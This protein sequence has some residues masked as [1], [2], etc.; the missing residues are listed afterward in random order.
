METKLFLDSVLCAEGVY[1]LFA[2]HS[3]LKKR[4]QR[5]FEDKQELIDYARE[6]DSK[7]WDTFFALSS[8][9]SSKSRKQDNVAKIRSFFLDL[10]CGPS[11]D[12]E[13]QEQALIALR[14]FCK[15]TGVP[16]PTMINSGRGVHV[17]WPLTEEKEPED[18]MSVARSFKNKLSKYKIYADPAVTSDTARVLRVPTTHNHKADPPIPVKPIGSLALEPL[19]FDMFVEIFGRDTSTTNRPLMKNAV[20][21]KL[22]GNRESSFE[23]IRVKTKAG[24]GCEQLKLI[25]TDQE[26]TSEPMWRAGLSIA[27]FC[28]DGEKAAHRLSE[29]H[30]EY[31]VDETNRKYDLIKGPYTCV[32]FDE[33]S[34]DICPNCPNWG[35]VKSPIV[36]GNRY[37]EAE[38]SSEDEN[39][40]PSYPQPYFRGANGGVYH[41]STSLDGE[42][43][44]KL[45]YHND[46][47]V[48]KRVRDP[49]AGESAVM[50]LHLPKDG[51]REFTIP[52]SAITSREEF[53]KHIASQGVA[54]TKMDELMTYTTTWINELQANSVAEKAHRQFGWTDGSMTTF[55]LGN[56]KITADAIEFNPPSDQTVGLFPAFEPKGTLEEWKE[57]M[58]FWDRDGFELYQYV[59][60]TGFGSALMEMLNASCAGMHLHS[61]ESGVAKTTAVIAGLGIYGN[62]NEL[63]LNKDDTFAS[64]MNR[65]QV[66]HSILW[67][68]DEITNLTPLQASNLIYQFAAG[69][70]RNRLT[71]SGN[72]ERYR[73]EPWSLL[74]NTTGNASI[75]ERVSMAKAMSKAEAQRMLECYV[76]N[77]RHLFDN[78]KDPYAFENGV[79]YQQYGTAAIPYVQYIMRNRDEI[80]VLLEKVKENVDRI[81]QLDTTNRFW[82]AHITA[83][84]TGLMVAKRAELINFDTKKVFKW[85]IETLLPQNKRNTETSD[86]SVFDIM[87]DFFTEHISN[88]LQIESTHDNRK[89]HDNGLDSLVIPDAI[90]RG[91]LVARYE[92]D[93]Q[94]FYVVPKILKSWCGD[95]QINYAHLLK[96]IK[97]H[98]EGKRAKV[99]LGKGTK[100]NLPPADVIVMKFSTDE[101]EESGD[102]KNL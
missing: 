26:N 40:L 91:K 41:R 62:P 36:L 63:L 90:A 81:G 6:L 44:E 71:S 11:K 32:T 29:R 58:S 43:D 30:P 66:Y 21:D 79:K 69:Q 38:T 1:C 92:T 39:E 54:V 18:W 53:R 99:R 76:P 93:T 49:E 56:K 94:K 17:Y 100:L 20:M 72:I 48:V 70:Q 59:V 45:I 87:N 57:L 25:M 61:V 8:F 37:K 13:T 82:S 77:V 51:I 35:K 4:N 101:D 68:V 31:D 86:A 64:K 88:I 22:M 5:F 102:S 10:D 97:E 42:V 46:L 47:Y 14:N 89:M 73:G 7:G 78:V 9:Q 96:Q 95:L 24:K 34:P 52:L 85:V 75:I 83:T 3:K 33:N 12:F 98:C 55:I 84:I 60:G 65:G 15:E 2:S 19:K 67:G 74:A 80:R 27:R 50:R 16:R 23:A 28:V